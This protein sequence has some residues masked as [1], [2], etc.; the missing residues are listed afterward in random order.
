MQT[1][2]YIY[3]SKSG[4]PALLVNC[5]GEGP[6]SAEWMIPKSLWLKQNEP[7]VWNNAQVINY[8]RSLV[9]LKCIYKLLLFYYW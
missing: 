9:I 4:D 3:H 1:T 2:I 5:N 7:E 6:L 8:L